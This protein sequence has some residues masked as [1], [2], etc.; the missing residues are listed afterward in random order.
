MPLVRPLSGIGYALDRF[1]SERIPPRIRLPEE[2][3]VH[4]GRVAD[5]TD[6]VSPPFDVIGPEQRLALLERDPHNAVRLELSAEPD[7]HRAAAAALAEWLADG[8]LERRSD[9]TLYYYSHARPE[10]PDDPSV[11]GVLAR[12]LL[13]PFGRG[14]RA[15]EH[16]MA[17]PKADRL[18][19]LNATHTQL[20]PILAIYLDGS[21]RYPS[22]MSR[23]WTDEWRARDANDLLHT[24]AAVEA[25]E[26]LTG[27][28][29]RQQ[30]F[31]ADGHHRYE[32][33]LAYQAQVRAD[34][35]L[36]DAASGALAADWVMMVLVNAQLE[37]LE[38]RATHR[39]VRGVDELALRGL[40]SDP[41]PLFQSFPVA[42][43]ELVERLRELRDAEEPAFGMVMREGASYLLVGD[44]EGVRDRMRREAMSTAVQRLD[45][46]VL[47]R[48][49][50][51][52]RL[53]LESDEAG[54]RILYTNDSAEAL[55]RVQSGEAQAAFLV[56]ATRMDQL[57]AVA[58]AGDV[59]PE[60]AT[61][62]YPK[63]LTGMVFY[64][65]ED[66]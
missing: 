59:M 27:Y 46:S 1:G 60:K 22:L 33:A 21:A 50:F 9:P 4:P 17:S 36:H 43:E 40:V 8:T 35:Q 58:T 5:L 29:S 56:R 15:H 16:T 14:I 51:A 49:V 2:P 3:P 6:L 13:E 10:A 62:F 44:A 61:Y 53:G 55:A 52:D 37:Q 38:I 66:Q 18:G 12:V 65:L 7:P 30:L 20:S 42:P 54:K 48:S 45:L 11:V 19:L 24:L 47:H 25:D 39:L 31:I 32:T 57:A 28:L 64:P 34:A 23:A 26:Q 41:G 63:L